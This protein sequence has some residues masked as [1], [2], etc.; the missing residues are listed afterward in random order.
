[1]YA[2]VETGG[3][4]YKVSQGEVVAVEKMAANVGETLELKVL[5]VADDSNVT[6]A[7]NGAKVTAEVVGHIKG[8]KVL[9]YKYK[10]KKNVRKKN[11][12]R[13][14]YTKVKIVS[15]QA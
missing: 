8:D 4:Q 3:K 11:G 5:L 15:I 9:V 13:Q 2:I 14:Q 7:P 1:M 10:A 12:H 6:T